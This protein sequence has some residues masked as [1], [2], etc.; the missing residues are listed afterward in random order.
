MLKGRKFG[1]K[2]SEKEKQK[3]TEREKQGLKMAVSVKTPKSVALPTEASPMP[4]KVGAPSSAPGSI[5][6]AILNRNHAVID[7]KRLKSFTELRDKYY[8]KKVLFEDPLFPA[9]D[10]SLFYTQKLPITFEWRRPPVAMTYTPSGFF[11]DRLIRERE[12]KDGEGSLNKPLRF[13]GQDFA[14]IK[15]ESLQKKVLFEDD[16]FPATVDSLGFKELGQKS[17]KVK[18]IVWKRPKEI[19][20]SP[21]FIVGGANRTDIC[22][23]D[24]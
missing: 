16:V 14:A 8:H 23:G 4:Y 9:D 17:N 12:R 2:V 7:A 13:G 6:S 1:D 19:C 21:Q 20:E 3:G 10:S 11:C 24:L 22:Q 18:N 15:Q 5:Y